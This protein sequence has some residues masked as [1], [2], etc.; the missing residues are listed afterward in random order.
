MLT[1]RFPTGVSIR[2][3]QAGF[4]RYTESAWELYTKDPAKGGTWVASISPHSGAIVEAVPACAVENPTANLTGE[5][6]LEY[7]VENITAL[8]GYSNRRKLKK[9]KAELA[10]FNAQTCQWKG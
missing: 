4:V 7:V 10:R 2:Y 8:D 1:V 6:A 3:N 9:L 5:K